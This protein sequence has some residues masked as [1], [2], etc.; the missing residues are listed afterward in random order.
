M[1]TEG[2]WMYRDQHDRQHC[3]NQDREPRHI[4]GGIE[5]LASAQ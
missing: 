4:L 3:A 5:V 1:A 2:P